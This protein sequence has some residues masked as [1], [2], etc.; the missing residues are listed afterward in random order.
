M[1]LR[2]RI[3]QSETKFFNEICITQKWSFLTLINLE[4]N[5]IPFNDKILKKKTNVIFW[6]R[7]CIQYTISLKKC[8][9][10]W[11]SCFKKISQKTTNPNYKWILSNQRI[12]IRTDCGLRKT[13]RFGSPKNAGKIIY[14]KVLG[15]IKGLEYIILNRNNTGVL[16]NVNKFTC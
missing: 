2:E 10:I 14:I 15:K 1:F 4:F 12:E 9:L 5:K 16:P 8:A 7:D 3:K 6:C 13:A 11:C